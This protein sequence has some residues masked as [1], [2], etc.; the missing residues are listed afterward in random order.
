MP[1]EQITPNQA[2]EMMQQKQIRYVDVRSVREFRQGHPEGAINIPLLDFNEEMGQMMPNPDFQKVS[3]AHL[4]PTQPLIVGCQAGGRSQ[5]AC[6][7]LLVMGYNQLFNMQG[8]FG[9]SPN[10]AG[11]KACGLPSTAENGENV[12]YES[13]KQKI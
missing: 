6:E 10:Q 7:L 2:L 5:K 3:L 11:W 1:I 8:G 4:D 13:L 9:G 12:S